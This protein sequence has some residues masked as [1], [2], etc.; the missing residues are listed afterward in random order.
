MLEDK[1]KSACKL[2]QEQGWSIR[3]GSYIQPNV[4]RCCPLAALAVVEGTL[5]SKTIGTNARELSWAL[6]L[7]ES[8][9]VDFTSGFDDPNW[10]G[11]LSDF[12]D[13]KYEGPISEYWDLG[14]KVR[15]WLKESV[16]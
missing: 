5:D 14:A 13:P 6:N 12:G 15:K 3:P 2:M 1:I 7:Q 11:I 10:E 8:Q 4:K 9:V 16:S